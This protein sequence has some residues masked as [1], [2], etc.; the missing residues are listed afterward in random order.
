MQMSKYKFDWQANNQFELFI[1]GP[2]FYPAMLDDIN[3]AR[4]YILLEMYLTSPGQVSSR[5]FSALAAAAKRGVT[6]CV[7]L[8]D[9]GSRD[10][11][12]AQR[13]Q[14]RDQGI[15]LAIYNP[16]ATSKRSLMLFRDH[17]KLLV[18]DDRVAYVGGAALS[19]EL[20][21]AD[22]PQ[23]NW[24]E[25]MV[26]IHGQN[27]L[28]WRQLFCDTWS[29]WSSFMLTRQPTLVATHAQQRGRVTMTQGPRLLE[30]KRSFLN[31]VRSAKQRVWFCT[32][33]FAPSRKLR[34]SLCATAARGVDVRILLPGDITDNNMAR[35]LAQHYYAQLLASGVRIYEYQPRF[36]H[37][38]VVLCD[39]WVSIGSCNVDRWN[40]L[41][42]LDANQE[43]LDSAFSTEVANMFTAD[44]LSSRE[45]T[46]TDWRQRS[47]LT[48]IRIIFWSRYVHLADV[49]FNYLGVIRYWR[50]LRK[51]SRHGVSPLPSD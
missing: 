18:V 22:A 46:S 32:A 26:K 4:H 6:T 25:N 43:I 50:Q 49:L 7:L 51:K 23:H 28:Q 10:I 45:I 9:F 34:A 40:F 41:W 8:D 44:F 24:R 29:S 42:N 2:Q 19:D 31:H 11:T 38:K 16:L 21:R 5:F 30:I 12:E 14:L 33:Y 37:A 3:A 1:D 35:Y 17:R 48:R 13:Q 27:V 47:L 20:D 36:L 39:D 15:E